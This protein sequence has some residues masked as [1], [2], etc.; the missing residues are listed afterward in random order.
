MQNNLKISCFTSGC[1]LLV[2]WQMHLWN[3]FLIIVIVTSTNSCPTLTE[4]VT[5][6][7]SLDC[8][9]SKYENLGGQYVKIKFK[10]VAI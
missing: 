1:G 6:I 8:I 4:V 10:T 2:E 5:K 7:A 9:L 3:L